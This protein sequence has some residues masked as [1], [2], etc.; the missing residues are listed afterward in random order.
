MNRF[1]ATTRT[2]REALLVDGFEAHR[3][4]GSPYCTVVAE[5]DD[6]ETPDP[7][8][9]F[10]HGESMLNLDCSDAELERLDRFLA[11]VGG[12]TVAERRSPEEA[13]GTNVRMKAHVDHG[14]VAQLV[15]RL[16]REVYD[17]PADYRLWVTE[18]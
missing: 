3:D 5:A 16:F 2:D 6:P 15:E 7:W 1:D 9:Q 17:R 13:E 8:V 12:L 18:I 11:E 10:D 4:R 14:R